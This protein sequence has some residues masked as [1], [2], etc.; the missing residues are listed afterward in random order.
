MFCHSA[1]RRPQLLAR[2]DAR[3]KPRSARCTSRWKSRVQVASGSG[4]T[5]NAVASWTGNGAGHG[6]D[7][8][9][10]R[11]LRNRS[12]SGFTFDVLAKPCVFLDSRFT[13]F[14]NNWDFT[15][16]LEHRGLLR[17]ELICVTVEGDRQYRFLWTSRSEYRELVN[18]P[19]RRKAN[20]THW[21]AMGRHQDD[22]TPLPLAPVKGRSLRDLSADGLTPT[23]AAASVEALD[24]RRL[25]F[26]NA[27][28][29]KGLKT[30]SGSRRFS[31]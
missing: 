3:S 25:V 11:A 10:R 16:A 20:E 4:E 30:S 31:P 23:K 19:P 22:L 5:D 1:Q 13:P 28:A 6:A 8:G 2:R 15:C 12:L 7:V 14:S 18:Y 29:R 27:P 24:A 21:H 26:R 17:W 9:I